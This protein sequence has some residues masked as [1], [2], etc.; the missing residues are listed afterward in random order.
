MTGQL[1]LGLDSEPQCP[2][3]REPLLVVGKRAWCVK[4]YASGGCDV[5]QLAQRRARWVVVIWATYRKEGNDEQ[6]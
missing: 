1:A 2:H 4:T 6:T 3:C 5:F